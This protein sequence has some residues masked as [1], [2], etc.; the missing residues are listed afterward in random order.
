[1]VRLSDVQRTP[2]RIPELWVPCLSSCPPSLRPSSM[3][4]TA[5]YSTFQASLETMVGAE[6]IWH[7]KKQDCL[8]QIK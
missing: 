4:G 3:E 7:A 6:C 1:M 2:S 5:T 8:V